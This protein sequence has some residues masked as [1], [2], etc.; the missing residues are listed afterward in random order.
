MTGASLQQ[1]RS[2]GTLLADYRPLPG[3]ADELLD[4]AGAIRQA[5]L[6][7]LDHLSRLSPAE[8]QRRFSRGDQYLRDAGVYFRQYGE[9]AVA[10]R[11][12]PLSHIPVLIAESEWRTIAAG[13]AQRADLLEAVVA[14][15]YGENRLVAEGHLPASLIATSPEWLRPLVGVR[16][17]SGHFLHF[18]AFEIGRGPDGTWWVLGDRTQAPSGAGF[19]LENRV[20][21]ARI[22]SEVFRQANVHRLAGFFRSFR[23][24]LMSLRGDDG[25]RAGILTPGPWNETYYEHAYIARYLGLMLL[26]G[27]DLTVENGRLMVRTVAGLQPISVLWRRLDASWADPLDLNETS[28]LGTPGLVG[29]IRQG[30]VAMVNAL[31]A[32]VLETRALLAFL[33]RI[34]DALLG[35]R[36]AMPNIATWW[37]GQPTELAHVKANAAQMTIAPALSTG[38]PF[39]SDDMLALGG[40]VCRD[41]PDPFECWL[42]ENAAGVVGQEAV[43]LSTT[44]V[45]EGGRL[46]PRPMSLRIFLARTATGWQAM[47]GGFARIGGSNDATAIAMRQGGAV[48]DV[49][50]VGEGPVAED[51]ML[52]RPSDPYIRNQP[53]FLP[54]RSADNLYWLG[55]YVE[56]TEGIMRL[57]RAYH[58]RLAETGDPSVPLIATIARHLECYGVELERGIPTALLQTLSAAVN[59]ASKIRDRFSV[60]GWMALT[61][62]DKT[63]RRMANTVTAG[64]DAARAFSILLRK[65]TGFSGLVHENMYRFTGWRF[66]TIGRS[67]ERAHAMAGML[68]AFADPQAPEGG[69]DLAIEV[70]DSTMTHRRRYSVTTTRETV[71]DLLA[72]DAMNPRSILYQLTVIRDQANLLPAAQV[73]GQMSALSRA[74]LKVHTDLALQTP[75]TLDTAELLRIGGEIAA[76]SEGLSADYMS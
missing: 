9:G 23:E 59:S 58:G 36:L 51:T 6:P 42:D 7:L 4:G 64:D 68:A 70:G 54:S 15:L 55:R 67:L 32:G 26:E 76:L 38:L 62:L 63:A 48:A 17:P 72:L 34:C 25:S 18:L 37:C 41:T 44:P 61:D 13:L 19:A 52:A 33:P 27:E 2:F 12:W 53:A 60:D 43:T 28:Q 71:V 20:A 69:F 49:W 29:A 47:P 22:F 10:E 40:E 56:R 11:D 73:H 14:D 16:P 74:M 1:V 35:A 66:L 24:A 75:E 3:V 21:T 65:V 50:V 31:G 39:E 46:V 57:V 30:N 8:M 5:W 45:Y